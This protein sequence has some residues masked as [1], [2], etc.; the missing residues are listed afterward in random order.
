MVFLCMVSFIKYKQAN[1]VDGN[2]RMHE[3]VIQDLYCADNDHVFFKVL[4]P[5]FLL[6]EVATHVPTKAFNLL[7]QIAFEY[8]KLLEYQSDT[9]YLTSN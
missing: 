3:A 4:L 1:L 6:P 9:I 2:E 5:L 7:V 8:S